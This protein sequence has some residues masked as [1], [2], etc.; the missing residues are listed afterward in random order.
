MASQSLDLARRA[1]SSARSVHNRIAPV[2]RISYRA[3]R[4]PSPSS[5]AVADGATTTGT[6][7]TGTA[8]DAF[9]EAASGEWEA[10]TATFTSTGIPMQLPENVVP[11]AY[12]EWGVELHDWQSQCSAHS[13]EPGVLVYLLRR[14]MPTVG[15]EADAVAFKEESRRLFAAGGG[16]ASGVPRPVLPD[17][18]FVAGPAQTDAAACKMEVEASFPDPDNRTRVRVVLVLS[19]HWQSKAWQLS[20]VDMHQEKWDTP[21]VPIRSLAGC[22]GGMVVSGEQ[23]K[24]LA[25]AS[26]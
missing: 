4:L 7:G 17:G 12:R 11:G 21:Y 19:R 26:S 13:P 6:S 9:A 3:Q 22:G 16:W 2:T 24:A 20:N 5:A 23:R 25:A 8:W 18:A 14:L 15:C 10:V 1:R